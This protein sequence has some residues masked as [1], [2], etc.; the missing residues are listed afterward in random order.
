MNQVKPGIYTTEFW[1][2]AV[3]NI[4]LAVFTILAYR[5]LLSAQEAELW[6]E[7]AEAL[8]AAILPIAMAIITASYAQSRAKT[9][10]GV[11]Q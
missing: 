6:L 4:T 2:T 10:T 3:S 1:L 11:N 7:L 8:A 9:K 5:G